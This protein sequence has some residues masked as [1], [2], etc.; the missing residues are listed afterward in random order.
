MTQ[1]AGKP[2]AGRMRRDQVTWYS[3]LMLG[4]FT[5][6]LNIQGNILPFLQAELGLSYRAVSLH[7][8]AIAVGMITVGLF[9][10]QIIRHLGRRRALWLAAGGVLTG[11]VLLCLA[12]AAWMSIGSCVLI[13][14]PGALIPA[15]VFAILAEVQGDHREVAY[16][17]ASALSYAFAIMGPLAMSLC[18]SLSLGWR[19]AVLLGAVMGGAIVLTYRR[20]PIADPTD[21]PST[22]RVSLP[23]TYWAYWCMLTAAVALEYS[24]LFWAPAF[25]ERAV[26]L[27]SAEAAASGAA[28]S[29]AMLVGRIAGS[30]LVRRMPARRLF[31]VALT[32]ALIG[33]AVYWGVDQPVAAVVG[34]FILGL[35]VAPLYPLTIGFAIDAAGEQSAAASARFMLAVGV[36]ILSMPAL[37]GGLADEVGLRPAHLILPGLVG[38]ALL[39]LIV[40]MVLG[41]RGVVA[42]Q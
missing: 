36:A 29:V 10:N 35:G 18:L 27:T 22:E 6:L 30:A 17:E 34:L 41:R 8:S 11:A 26:G 5:Y 12:P 31:L 2:N 24:V 15:M 33:F 9:G 40:A 1:S 28:F 39:C 25:L 19:S 14:V 23:A 3:Y 37:L 32:T 4:F 13:G 16:A 38:V 42:A 20:L 7:F 21:L